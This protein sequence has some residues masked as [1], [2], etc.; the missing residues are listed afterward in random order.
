MSDF[1]L[2]LAC[3][4]DINLAS[5]RSR[6]CT[7]WLIIIFLIC[8]PANTRHR[9]NVKPILGQRRRRW[10]NIGLTLGRRLVFA[11]IYVHICLLYET[12]YVRHVPVSIKYFYILFGLWPIGHIFS[13]D[14]YCIIFSLN[15][16]LLH[17]P[18]GSE[19]AL[20]HTWPR[21]VGVLW[22]AVFHTASHKQDF[23]ALFSP[24]F[25]KSARKSDSSRLFIRNIN[26]TRSKYPL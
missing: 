25:Y 7:F 17:R 1:I 20:S 15:I 13:Q 9:P 3:K 22:A 8:I 23:L 4:G 18:A 14:I 6:L 16:G 2:S 10:T 26:P 11:G 19:F 5:Q 24:H 12:V 21:G